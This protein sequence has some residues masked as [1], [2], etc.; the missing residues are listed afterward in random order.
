MTSRTSKLDASI[1][2]AAIFGLSV[3][4]P[5]IIAIS[6]LINGWVLSILWGWF[7]VPVFGVQAITLGQAI[8]LS[9]VVSFLTYQYIDAKKDENNGAWTAVAVAI[10]RPLFAL[11]FGWLIHIIF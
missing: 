9:M 4:V 3:A 11:F 5:V 6:T 7:I 8:G 10:F 1:A 2:I